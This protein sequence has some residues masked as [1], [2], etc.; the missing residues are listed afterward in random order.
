[1]NPEK[2]KE[3]ILKET[4]E[5]NI[6]AH[7]DRLPHDLHVWIEQVSTRLTDSLRYLRASSFSDSKRMI[8]SKIPK[9]GQR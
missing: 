1:M 8:V 7:D 2:V 4:G 5:L 3:I 6:I 9:E